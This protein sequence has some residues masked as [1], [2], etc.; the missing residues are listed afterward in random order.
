[1]LPLSPDLF[2]IGQAWQ[3]TPTTAGTFNNVINAQKTP[4]DSRIVIWGF[5]NRSPTP[6]FV[7][8]QL[9]IDGD[10]QPLIPIERYKNFG[11]NTPFG[12]ECYFPRDYILE[13]GG[14]RA[15]TLAVYS[16]PGADQELFQLNGVM[17]VPR[18]LAISQNI[19]NAT[20]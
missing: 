19:A 8:M 7:S 5:S 4:R 1:V 10:T 12:R 17:I 9:T 18:N 3:F 2:N 16:Y 13:I 20:T 6:Q 11:L 14:S 15:V